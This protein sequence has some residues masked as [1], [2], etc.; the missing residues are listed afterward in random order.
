M[1]Q[2]ITIILIFFFVSIKAD[3][4][5]PL[6]ID[7]F[8]ENIQKEQT[9]Y[10]KKTDGKKPGDKKKYEDLIKDKTAILGFWDFYID[11]NNKVYLSIRPEQFDSEFLMGFTRQSGDGYQFDGSSM[12]RDG[13]FFLK[14]V[15]ET[16][17]LVE[18]NTKFRADES[19]AIYK[20][21]KNHIPNSVIA[22][23]KI[24][25]KPHTETNA[26][27]VDASKFFIYDFV[28]V[29]RRTNNKY[30][31]DKENSYFNYIKSF[32][33]NSEIDFYLH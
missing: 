2:I 11:E 8:E 24:I 20:S 22:S 29:S 16:V 25:S 23:T 33:L 18:K 19:R 13:V 21:I 12:L 30:S 26:I 28:N 31:F 32:P 4:L 1:R 15:G 6:P 10:T 27:L 14:R 5:K 7:F 17:Q 9:D 3:P